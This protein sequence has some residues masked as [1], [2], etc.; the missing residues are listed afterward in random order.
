MRAN[1]HIQRDQLG[2]TTYT[3]YDTDHDT[4]VIRTTSEQLATQSQ[5]N[6][7]NCKHTVPY[8]IIWHQENTNLS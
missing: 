5:N 6:I 3:V 1:I 7:N 8:D 2:I 4:L